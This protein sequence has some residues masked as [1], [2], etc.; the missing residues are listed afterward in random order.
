MAGTA[1]DGA[2]SN[3]V[4]Y[5]I[6]R[7]L[8]LCCSSWFV[9]LEVHI[10]FTKAQS[11]TDILTRNNQKHGFTLLQCYFRRLILEPLCCDFHFTGSG[12]TYSVVVKA[13]QHA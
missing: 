12:L 11:V 5:E 3:E 13:E 9:D 4:T 8:D 7:K 10:Q 1:E 6:R 2:M